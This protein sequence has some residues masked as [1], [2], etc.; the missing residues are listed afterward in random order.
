MQANYPENLCRAVFINAPSFF[1]FAWQIVRL[2]L[3]LSLSQ[4]LPLLSLSLSLCVSLSLSS[5]SKPWGGVQVKPVLNKRT[6]AK[7]AIESGPARELV[8]PR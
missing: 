8:R 3:S 1:S 2:S 6:Q 7:I 4:P 5:L